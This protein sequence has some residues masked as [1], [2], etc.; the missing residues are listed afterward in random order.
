MQILILITSGNLRSAYR[1]TSIRITYT[2]LSKKNSIWILDSH[3]VNLKE[4]KIQYELIHCESK[5]EYFSEYQYSCLL[6]Y[7]M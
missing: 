5:R 7:I 1:K 2:L 6:Y 3:Y 4:Y